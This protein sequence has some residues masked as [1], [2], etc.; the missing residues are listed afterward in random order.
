[1]SHRFFA[2]LLMAGAVLLP[3]ART[4]TAQE[5]RTPGSLTPPAAQKV[6]RPTPRWPDGKVKL[7]APEGEKGIW[8]PNGR[9]I[10]AEPE[11]APEI[12][13]GQGRGAFSGPAFPGKP[14]ESEVPF[15][16]WAR[17]LYRYREAN[18]FEPHTRCKPSGGPRQFITPGGVEFVDVPGLAIYV[19]DQAGPY[20]YRVI[21]MDGRSHP[22]DL[23]PSYYGHSV[24]HW[25]GDTLVVD[26]V[27]F[28]ERFWFERQG[29]PHTDQLHLIE[30]FTRI[31]LNN[32]K[33]E[34][35]IDDPGA[36]TRTWTTGFFL[37]WTPGEEAETIEYICQANN[38]AGALMIGKEEGVDRSSPIVP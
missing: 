31:D 25:E 26:S 21:Y 8:Q 28:N 20:T 4:A 38:R 17:A 14:K 9:P 37:R 30:R 35:T 2:V 24:G 15:Q 13:D 32:M 33:I 19:I 34:L 29:A 1:V 16:P 10:L 27:G 5:P 3:L 36:Y 23:K 11:T 18:L 22:K 12:K 6:N 7:G